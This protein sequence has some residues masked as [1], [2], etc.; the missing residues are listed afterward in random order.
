MP[1]PAW[2]NSDGPEADIVISSRCRVARCIAG[3]RFPH[4]ASIEELREIQSAIEKAIRSSKLGLK[5]QKNISDAE[6]DFLLGTRMISPDFQFREPFRSLFVDESRTISVMVNEEDHL[7]AQA[8]TAGFSIEEAESAVQGVVDQLSNHLVFM[9]TEKLGYLAASPVNAGAARRRSALFHLLGLALTRRLN[10]VLT[11]LGDWGVVARGLYGEASRGVG[12]FFQ[13]SLT[14]GRV[15]DFRGA[16]NY[17]INEERAARA[18]ISELELAELAAAA[19]AS[20]IASKEITLA[21]AL[22][23]LA[24]IRWAASAN[25]KGFD[26]ITNE[27][28]F[29]TSTME[30]HGTQEAKIASRHRAIFLRER[31]ERI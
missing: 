6:R 14:K 11:A 28:D 13:V 5:Q 25:V 19:K 22:K 8:L 10:V 27:V 30:V 9:Q 31:F 24:W 17:L 21:D 15:E 7:R 2:L 4:T 3:F 12:G 29:W 18:Q 1:R 26:V 16:C 23:A 20:A